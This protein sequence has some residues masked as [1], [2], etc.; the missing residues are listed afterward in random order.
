M[1]QIIKEEIVAKAWFDAGI[2]TDEAKLQLISSDN[3]VS[4]SGEVVKVYGAKVLAIMH[5]LA[6]K[7]VLVESKFSVA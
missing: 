3:Y 6:K 7:P 5:S 2:S 1:S 4:L